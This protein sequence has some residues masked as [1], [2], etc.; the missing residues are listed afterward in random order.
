MNHEELVKQAKK[1]IDE[2]FVNMGGKIDNPTGYEIYLLAATR[3]A[4]NFTNAIL[5]LCKNGF[6]DDSLPILR[7]LIEHTI[8]MRWITNKDTTERFDLFTNYEINLDLGKKWSGVTLLDKMLEV[9]FNKDYYDL[10]VKNTYAYSHVNALTLK[11]GEFYKE[12]DVG[13]DHFSPDS[14]FSVVA[15]MLGHV[16]KALDTHF[17]APFS[18]YNEIW[19][20]IS[21]DKE[22]GQ[23]YREAKKK[24]IE[25]SQN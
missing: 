2:G 23:K 9:G 21:Y 24:I 5:L 17:V 6:S 1:L 20:Q 13:P 15:Q 3:K 25:D 4:F 18:R 14:I 7:S 22:A 19:D 10:V 12:M 8:N 16:M 11:W